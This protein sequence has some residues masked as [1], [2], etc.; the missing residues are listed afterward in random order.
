MGYPFASAFVSA[1]MFGLFL[2]K[3]VCVWWSAPCSVNIN[4]AQPTHV[5]V[6]PCDTAGPMS[7]IVVLLA[8]LLTLKQI[9]FGLEEARARVCACIYV[10]TGHISGSISGVC[11][12][13]AAL[14]VT[15]RAGGG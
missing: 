7:G 14:S 3:C 5:T 4:K 13:A 6:P 12:E 10:C 9:T 2:C 8:V 15:A 11:C 1:A